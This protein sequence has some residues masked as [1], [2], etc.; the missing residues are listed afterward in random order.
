MDLIYKKDDKLG[1]FSCDN[2]KGSISSNQEIIIN[3]NFK[4]PQFDPFIVF[5]S[6]KIF[7]LFLIGKYRGFTRN[8]TMDRAKS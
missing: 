8:W 4:A 2:M 3:F 5:I 7:I 1:Y 6:F